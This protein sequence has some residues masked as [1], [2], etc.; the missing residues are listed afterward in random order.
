MR[1]MDTRYEKIGIKQLIRLEW[2]NKTLDMLLAG[3]DAMAIRAELKI[4]LADKKQSGGTGARGEKTYTMA[5]GLLMQSW[6]EPDDVLISMRDSA[7]DL[8]R[9]L[10]LRK[11]LPLHWAMF[12]AAYPF[13][14][15]VARQAG[16]LLNLQDQVTQ[17]QIV[18]RLKEQY[19]DRQTISRYARYVI[20]SFV[21]WGV[22][23]DTETKGCYEK[24]DPIVVPDQHLA[25]L[26]LEGALHATPDGKGTLSMLLNMPPLFPFQLSVLTGD[27]ISQTNHRLDVLNTAGFDDKL[28]RLKVA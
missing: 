5:I 10:P 13:W 6:V 24:V 11:R 17:R 27:L 4:Y 7:L 20:R 28:I 19:G 25:T 14:L 8:A 12:S 22:L 9:S 16:R 3:M 23:Q 2:M 1:V 26:L 21:A 18:T 15:N